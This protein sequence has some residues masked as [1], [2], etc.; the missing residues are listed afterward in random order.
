MT[1]IALLTTL[2]LS[3]AQTITVT[4]PPAT[5]FTISWDQPV[6]D[7]PTPPSFRFWCDGTIAKNYAPRELTK[8]ATPNADGTVTFTAQAPGLPAG[9]HSCLV[10]AFNEIGEV[11][12]V[13]IPI[14]VGTAPATPLRLK[15][16]VQ[17]GGGDQ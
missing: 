15:V 9:T 17:I 12:S 5:P 7:A 6:E 16:V 4:I 8:A 11:K 2:A 1:L 13:A 14:T 3:A 10:S